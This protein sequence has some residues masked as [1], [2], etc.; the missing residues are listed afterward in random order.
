[1]RSSRWL[2]AL[3]ALTFSAEAGAQ[4]AV[5]GFDAQRLYQSAPGA[6]WWVMDALDMHGK[7]G[8]AA[9]LTVG[10]SGSDL[11]VSDGV[12]HIAVVSDNAFADV[13]FAVAFLE[14]LRFYMN[15]AM[16]LAIDGQSGTVGSYTFTAPNVTIG[17]NPDTI[18]DSRL[19][20]DAR[21]YGKPNGPFR[22]G[23]GAQLILPSGVRSDYDTDG[24]YRGMI[25]LL[26]AG[27]IGR[28]AYA[29]QVGVHIRPLDDSPAPGSPE[30]SE[31][32]FGVAAGARLPAFTGTA[33]IVGP[34]VFGA[35]A[36]KNVFG[37]TSTALEGLFGV[38]LEGTGD[39]TRQFRVKLGV[40]AGLNPVFGEPAWRIVASFEVFAFDIYRSAL[41]R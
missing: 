7:L 34:E 10:Y 9:A 27:D 36:F 14:R 1:M 38:R 25:C 18:G 16:P 30:G 5:Q 15:L 8:G 32:L 39:H 24:T 21:I 2:A 20:F 40:G 6:G 35:S 3:A 37:T 23:A 26:F 13:G 11:R 28:F 22:F 41:V 19:G 33:L 17:N 4:Q 29:G 12:Q 31:L